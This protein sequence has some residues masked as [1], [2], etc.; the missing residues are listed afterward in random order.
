MK[1]K[2]IHLFL[3]VFCLIFAT[4]S[5]SKEMVKGAIIATPQNVISVGTGE[6]VII[7]LGK[8]DGVIVGDILKVFESDDDFLIGEIGRCAVTKIEDS[9]SVCEVIKLSAEA[10]KGDYVEINKLEYTDPRIYPLVFT[11]LNE[12][13]TPYEP[14]KDIR[15]YVHNIYDEKYNITGLSEKIRSEII[16]I[17]SQ[18]NRI[19]VNPYDLSGYITYPDKYFYIDTGRSRKETIGIVKEVMK[20]T[21]TNVVIMGIYNTNGANINVTLYIVDK[22]RL[23]KEMNLTLNAKEYSN[24]MNDIVVPYKPIKEKEY[25]TYNITYIKKDYFP[26]RDEKR[27][28]IKSESGKDLNFRYKV[29]EKKMD[30]N[31]IGVGNFTLKINGEP[32]SVVPGKVYSI[33]FEKGMKRIWLSFQTSFFMNEEHLYSSQAKPIEKEIILDLTRE[34]NLNI[35]LTLDPTYGKEKADIRVFRKISDDPFIAKPI[36]TEV[37]KRP[38]VDV[39]KD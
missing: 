25:V 27:D 38:A 22:N 12:I 36:F 30:F 4:E 11:L 16:N 26:S 31:R 35:E 1:I 10:G 18:K 2:I 15:V 33:K 23:D 37:D 6:K 8:N 29:S 7:N 9:T 17:F 14:Q 21:D 34:D 20:R 24:I 13:V 3:M 32:I 28:I 5:F 19:I 39:Y